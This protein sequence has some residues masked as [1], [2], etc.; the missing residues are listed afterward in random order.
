MLL[1]FQSHTCTP[2]TNHSKIGYWPARSFVDLL[3]N[4]RDPLIKKIRHLVRPTGTMFL[5]LLILSCDGY[6]VTTMQ[7][8]SS[9]NPDWGSTCSTEDAEA[10]A[11]GEARRRRRRRAKPPADD[12]EHSASGDDLARSVEEPYYRR[13]SEQHASIVRSEHRM[14]CSSIRQEVYCGEASRPDDSRC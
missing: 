13:S 3:S 14:I 7:G 1:E 10:M 8:T 12:A 11:R 2:L 9:A 6:V 4:Q 5:G